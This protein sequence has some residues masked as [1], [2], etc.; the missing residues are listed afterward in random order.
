MNKLI[1][2]PVVIGLVLFGFLSFSSAQQEHLTITTYYPSPF[3]SYRDLSVSNQL[4]VGP[5]GNI[6]SITVPETLHP[7]AITASGVAGGLYLVDQN[8]ISTTLTHPW[9]TGQVFYWYNLGSKVRLNN[10]GST[11][12]SDVMTITTAGTLNVTGNLLAWSNASHPNGCYMMSYGSTS[13]RT[14][15]PTGTVDTSI[16]KPIHPGST[17]G[18]IWCCN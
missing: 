16:S 7:G 8:L 9:A 13:G 15:C 10:A 12:A 14:Q 1:V 17:G 11:S 6:F 4:Y 2:I 3:G 5:I 18:Y